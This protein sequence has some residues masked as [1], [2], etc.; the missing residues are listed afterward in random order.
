MYILTGLLVAHKYVNKQLFGPILPII[1]IM[2]YTLG[3]FPGFQD[4]NPR[5]PL[6]TLSLF[7]VLC[8]MPRI[9]FLFHRAVARI[10]VSVCVAAFTYHL[11]IIDSFLLLLGFITVS[12]WNGLFVWN[13]AR[14]LRGEARHE[15]LTL[16]AMGCGA[17]SLGD[18]S[19]CARAH[20]PSRAELKRA[21]VG[22]TYPDDNGHNL[23]WCFAL[24]ASFSRKHF[25]KSH[26]TYLDVIYDQMGFTY[27]TPSWR[28]QNIPTTMSWI[29][30]VVVTYDMYMSALR[31]VLMANFDGS[32]VR[33]LIFFNTLLISLLINDHFF[34]HSSGRCPKR[35]CL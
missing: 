29:S 26:P 28:A 3:N 19:T 4:H 33:E 13:L 24:D 22:Y 30:H 18:G 7:K 5:L 11:D 25:D 8:V 2:T 12:Y 34:R 16:L 10:L 23:V 31:N 6:S 14:I 35:G 17:A 21:R 1:A 15:L 27:N 9:G 32:K 20:K